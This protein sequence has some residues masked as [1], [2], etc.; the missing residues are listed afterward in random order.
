M[1]KIFLILVV[2]VV[3]V[4]GGV[5][6][7][8]SSRSLTPVEQQ[9]IEAAY[10]DA[11]AAI[12]TYADEL[13]KWY[14]DHCNGATKKTADALIGWRMKWKTIKSLGNKEKMEQFANE[15]VDRELISAESCE[16]AWMRS[17]VG[18]AQQWGDIEDALAVQMKC[19]ALSSEAK[20][21]K[22]IATPEEGSKI[23]DYD[24]IRRKL[25]DSLINE[26]VSIVASEIATSIVIQIAVSSGVITAG[27]LS[28]PATF[29]IGLVMGL[30][31]D[32]VID[33]FT[34]PSGKVQKSLDEQMVKM[35]AQQ[36]A[37]FREKMKEVLD[38]RYGEW[39]K[40]LGI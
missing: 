21:E 18:V 24:L 38:A 23:G 35:G 25:R 5:Y 36:K 19:Y 39:K 32:T 3:L 6:Y 16:E 26:G 2:I 30:L 9:Y 28:A 27:T 33:V 13:E 15:V 11:Q 4:A 37:M 31:V 40:Q 1:K 14:L 10:K 8:F 12:D 20:A 17:I 7:L 34:D 29:G 22:M